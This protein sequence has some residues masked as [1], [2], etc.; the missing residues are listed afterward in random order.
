MRDKF[1]ILLGSTLFLYLLIIKS[2]VHSDPRIH[3]IQQLYRETAKLECRSGCEKFRHE[4]K[5]HTMLPAI[6]L[7]NTHII[8][9]YQSAQLNPEKDPYLF[10]YKLKKISVSYN[11]SASATFYMEYLYNEEENVVFF[12]WQEENPSQKESKRFYLHDNKLI[13]IIVT[14]DQQ[15]KDK[16]NYTTV[17]NFKTSDLQKSRKILAKG[18]KYRNLFYRLIEA[19]KWK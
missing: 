2:P 14:Y 6:G 16:T 19:E 3:K 10:S 9:Y 8:M 1:N 4:I 5:L 17:K 12:F 18:K 15:S 11:I 7:Q 13:K